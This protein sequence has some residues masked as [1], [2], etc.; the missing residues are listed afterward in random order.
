M[1][2]RF[3]RRVRLFPGV[4][5]N[6]S[7]SNVSLSVGPPGAKYT[8]SPRGNRTTVGIPGSGL[9]Y[10][11]QE[12]GADRTR[13]RRGSGSEARRSVESRLELGFLQRLLASADEKAFVDGLLALHRGDEQGALARLEEAPDDADASWLAGFLRM[14]HGPLASAEA[15]LRRVLEE[16]RGLGR[17]YR[18]YDLATRL[19]LPV[20]PE[21]TAHVEPGVRGLYLGLCEVCQAQDRNA[22]ARSAVSAL[23]EI[24]PEDV[25]ARL[26]LAELLLDEPA[27]RGAAQQVVSMT[28]SV[29]NDSFPHAA[30]LLYKAR[31]LRLLDMDTAAIDALTLALRRRKGRPPALLH[32]LRYERALAYERVGKR[33]RV[34]E[35]LERL[36]AE[37]PDFEDV[38]TRLAQ[39]RRT[40]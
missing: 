11:V 27:D 13:A 14:K 7:K 31:A 23:L 6:F 16:P 9:F 30:L 29:K 26:S 18:K 8:F 32:Q 5:L 28:A 10:T 33:R 21:V 24:E 37:A 1:S 36:Y 15:H 35:D 34:R 20:T 2:F 38:A 19:D 39:R 25:I 22:E 3:W 40:M 4:T 12:P 17:F